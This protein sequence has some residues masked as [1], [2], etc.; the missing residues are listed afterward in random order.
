MIRTL[1]VNVSTIKRQAFA[2]GEGLSFSTF[3]VQCA[4]GSMSSAGV[5][6]CRVTNTGKRPGSVVVQ[7]YL[8]FP[9][10]AGEPPKQLR[11]FS[12]IRLAAGQVEAGVEFDLVER[13]RSVWDPT[14]M[15]WTAV[16]GKFGL[17]VGQS[18]R[19]PNMQSGSFEV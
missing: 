1:N 15:A 6:D 18:S 17:H 3:T 16:K 14:T 10:S 13:D 8:S 11:G 5:K 19:D 9:T 4:I 12:K 7:L 2:F